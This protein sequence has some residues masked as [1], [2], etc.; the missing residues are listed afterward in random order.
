[1]NDLPLGIMTPEK[2]AVIEAYERKAFG[3]VR[4]SRKPLT[5]K[6]KKAKRKMAQASRRK[7]RR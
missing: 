7:N 4:F 5:Q 3:K 1:M 2:E 6:K